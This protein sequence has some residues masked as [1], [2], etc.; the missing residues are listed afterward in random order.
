MA[1][2]GQPEAPDASGAPVGD[3]DRENFHL[4]VAELKKLRLVAVERDAL[5]AEMNEQVSKP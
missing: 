4:V 5:L 3:A 1:A 2:L